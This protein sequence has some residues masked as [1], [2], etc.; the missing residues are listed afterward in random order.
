MKTNVGKIDKILRVIIAVL[1]FSTFF[2]LEGNLRFIAII[3]LVPLLTSMVSFC[4]LYR[5]I[6]VSTCSRK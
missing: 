1:L 4:P 2:V 6:G 3:G 5:I